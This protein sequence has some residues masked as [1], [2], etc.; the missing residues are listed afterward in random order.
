MTKQEKIAEAYGE[1]WE[2]VKDFVDMENGACCGIDYTN[3]GSEFNHP[4][5]NKMGIFQKDNF[6]E[7]WFDPNQNKHFWRPK[8]LD[9][10]SSNNGW[11]KIESEECLPK[12]EDGK[13][14]YMPCEYGIPRPDYTLLAI[15]IWEGWKAG[16][17]SHYKK[18]EIKEEIPPIF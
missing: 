12:R 4:S 16:V 2:K 17:I 3:K 9:G 6:T 14:L 13:T 11:I 1:H 8:T 10:I 18:I 7:T 15:K 5:L